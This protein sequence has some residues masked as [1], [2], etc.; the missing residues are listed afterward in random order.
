L[1]TASISDSTDREESGQGKSLAGFFI[2]PHMDFQNLTLVL[3]D[4]A[5]PERDSVAK[6]WEDNNGNVLRLGK[7]WETPIL[8]PHTVRLYGN[9]T[10]CLVLEQKLGLT[11]V[12][13]SDNLLVVIDRKWTGRNIRIQMLRE[14]LQT[15]FPQFVKPLVPKV[16]RA[17]VFHTTQELQDE[18]TG[19][20]ASTPVLVSE[21]IDIH[22]E[23]RAF[24]L[25]GTVQTCAL[26]EG[27]G[28][29]DEGYQFATDFVNTHQQLLP[30]TCVIDVG[31]L[32]NG[33]WIIIEANATW[34]AGLNG[35][36]SGIA[37]QCIAHATTVVQ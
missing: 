18:C 15:T 36:D 6:A 29:V 4:K 20:D 5:D 37:A 33:Q 16:F 30:Q 1:D 13:P 34:G 31:R 25:D 22:A 19:L 17:S 3:P 27:R 28:N 24:I 23:A 12:S 11:L 35:C 9:D 8:E 2:S 32:D 7:F 10:F 21:I 26:Y 14:A